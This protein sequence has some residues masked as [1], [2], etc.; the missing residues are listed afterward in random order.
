[1]RRLVKV[2]GYLPYAPINASKRDI[3]LSPEQWINNSP[4]MGPSRAKMFQLSAWPIHERIP[5]HHYCVS[6]IWIGKT[7]DFGHFQQLSRMRSPVESECNK[8]ILQLAAIKVLQVL[9]ETNGT[10]PIPTM[11]GSFNEAC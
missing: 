5:K 1:M 4:E 3:S 6:K 7:P 10:L 9:R 11:G 2:R 8:S